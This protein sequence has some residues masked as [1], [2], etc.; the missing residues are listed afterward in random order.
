MKI[1]VKQCLSVTSFWSI[2][3][4]NEETPA[5]NN[6]FRPNFFSP[7]SCRQ[8]VFFEPH[9]TYVSRFKNRVRYAQSR[10]SGKVAKI[11]YF[12]RISPSFENVLSTAFKRTTILSGKRL[13]FACITSKCFEY[14]AQPT[15]EYPICVP[16]CFDFVNR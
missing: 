1:S 4:L 13:P 9:L 10:S 3:Q 12:D 6:F 16:N 15:M 7:E 11:Q 14:V 8:W 2:N 5:N